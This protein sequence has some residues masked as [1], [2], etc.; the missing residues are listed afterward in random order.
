M[1]KKDVEPAR[2]NYFF[3][4]SYED[5]GKTIKRAF[6]L[7]E[8]SIWKGKENIK[9]AWI[10]GGIF[11]KIITLAENSISMI[12]IL[13]FGTVY[14][15]LF[16][17]FHIGAV[18]VIMLVFYILFSIVWIVDRV[19]LLLHKVRTDCPVCHRSAL[20]PWYRCPSCGELHRQLVPGKYGVW[21]HTCNC[22]QKIPSTFLNGRSKITGICPYCE[23]EL[24]ASEVKP[25]VFQLIGGSGSGK[26]VY[27]AAFYHELLEKMK[28]ESSVQYAIT[29]QYQPYFEDLERWFEGEICPSTVQLN[30]QMYPVLINTGQGITRQFSIYDIAGE[31]F[32]GDTINSQ[33]IQ[34]QFQYCDG[35]LFVIDPY[36]SQKIHID[37]ESE[38]DMQDFSDVSA[39]DVATSFINYFISTKHVNATKRSDKKLSVIITK[40]DVKEV[41]REIGLAKINAIYSAHP[42]QYKTKDDCRNQVC[43]Q[44][45]VNMGFS[46]AVDEL[47][48]HFREVQYYPVSAIGHSQD[49]TAYESWGIMQP[50]EWMLPSVDKSLADSIGIV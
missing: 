42:E 31:M 10:N 47:E 16:S 25:I 29:T 48:I 22:G 7:N 35:L 14:T 37:A 26:T 18:F 27:L 13:V 46:S 44:Y 4:A 12:M 6:A 15:L 24:V 38:V 21:K 45:L 36:S 28:T 43:R 23:S 19:Y 33:E 3:G 30:S 8:Y 41:K 17:V 49:G 1:S 11:K 50:F 39:N 20:I 40:A 9:D 34:R 32:N 5:L 2:R